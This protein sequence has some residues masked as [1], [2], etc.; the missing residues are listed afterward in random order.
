MHDITRGIAESEVTDFHD[1]R[2][3]KPAKQF[4]REFMGHDARKGKDGNDESRYNHLIFLSQSY[5]HSVRSG[6]ERAGEQTRWP[7]LKYPHQS[8]ASRD[9]MCKQPYTLLHPK[10]EPKK[11]QIL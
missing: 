7:T 1:T 4:V 3:G 11:R 9:W 2:A 6:P 5:C 8:G 10:G